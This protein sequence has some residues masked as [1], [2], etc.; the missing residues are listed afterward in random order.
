MIIST[1]YFLLNNFCFSYIFIEVSPWN[2]SNPKLRYQHRYCRENVHSR[3]RMSN[4]TTIAAQAWNDGNFS[5]HVDY[6]NIFFSE[7]LKPSILFA[8]FVSFESSVG[9]YQRIRVHEKRLIT[10]LVQCWSKITTKQSASYIIEWKYF[11]LA[12]AKFSL[13]MN[14]YGC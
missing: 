9:A 4:R 8:L 2:Q 7:T 3:M 13:K 10:L 5:S 6:C 12:N 11:T 14:G 1:A